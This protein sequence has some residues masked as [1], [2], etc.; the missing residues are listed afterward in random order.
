M[1]LDKDDLSKMDDSRSFVPHHD[2]DGI[3]A[4]I[5]T[6]RPLGGFLNAVFCNDL[7]AAYGRADSENQAAMQTI[8]TWIYNFAPSDCHGSPERVNYYSGRFKK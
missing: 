6:G 4:Y 2:R 7:M 1:K 5:E 3:I 8:V